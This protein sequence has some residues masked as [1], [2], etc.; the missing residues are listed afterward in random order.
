MLSSL[1]ALPGFVYLSDEQIVTFCWYLHNLQTHTVVILVKIAT[2]L[3]H[4]DLTYV[5]MNKKLKKNQYNNDEGNNENE[6]EKKNIYVDSNIKSKNND[7]N[8]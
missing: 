7:K 2:K 5:F 1:V 8:E 3:L 4:F 6:N